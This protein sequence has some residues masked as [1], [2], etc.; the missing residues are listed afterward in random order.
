MERCSRP[1]YNAYI[2]KILFPQS[3]TPV[4]LIR[5]IMFAIIFYFAILTFI[6]C[7]LL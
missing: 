4:N 5:V 6:G 1:E 7:L 2:K 3:D